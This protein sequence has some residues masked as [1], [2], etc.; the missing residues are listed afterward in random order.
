M[1]HKSADSLSKEEIMKK[2]ACGIC[3]VV[4]ALCA[5]VPLQA[6]GNRGKAEL[7]SGAAVITIDYGRPALKGRDMLSQLKVGEPWRMGMNQVTVLNTS[8]DLTF[9]SVKVPKGTYSLWLVKNEGDK[10]QLVFNSQTG[11]W[12]TEHDASKDLFKVP[13]TKTNV[14]APVETFTVDLRE[15]P[16]GGALDLTWGT[17]KLTADF[18]FAK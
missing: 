12:G 11:Q 7:K 10:F 5:V 13:L 6:Q 15:S 18:Q 16:K 2:P 1:I 9:G 4:L 8:V 14:S 3:C 17:A